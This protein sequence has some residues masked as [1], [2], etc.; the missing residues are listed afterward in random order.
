MGISKWKTMVS[1]LVTPLQN[2]EVIL[3]SIHLTEL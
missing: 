3:A 1:E 2:Q